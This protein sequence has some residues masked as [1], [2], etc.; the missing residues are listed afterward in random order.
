MPPRARSPR[1]I[2]LLMNA[3]T[4]W[5]WMLIAA[6]LF[7]FIWFFRPHAH[8]PPVGPPR[9]LQNLKP[10]AVASVQVRPGGT[11][12]LQIR[13]DRTN[14]TWQLSEPIAYPAQAPRIER[15]LAYLQRLAPVVYIS[16]NEIRNRASAD[17][18]YGFASPQ[19]SIF[20]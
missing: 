2:S 12:Q 13:V 14:H 10:E 7:A 16:A 11:A 8:K 19:A 20:L 15:L 17:E 3:R 1:S 4:T 5:A 6:G 18:D 9:I